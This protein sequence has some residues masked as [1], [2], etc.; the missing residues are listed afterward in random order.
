MIDPFLTHLKQTVDQEARA[1]AMRNADQKHTGPFMT[2]Y[3]NGIYWAPTS[4]V[5]GRGN[6]RTPE[7]EKMLSK[8]HFCPHLPCSIGLNDPKSAI[9]VSHKHYKIKCNCITFTVID[10]RNIGCEHEL[11]CFLLVNPTLEDAR[12]FKANDDGLGKPNGVLS[13]EKCS[14]YYSHIESAGCSEVKKK[15]IPANIRYKILVPAPIILC[16]CSESYYVFS[17]VYDYKAHHKGTAI[18]PKCTRPADHKTPNSLD[19]T[20]MDFNE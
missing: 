5:S 10:D 16:I 18:G 7:F 12:L 9:N 4:R 3:H 14:P 20:D 13:Y 11:N 2:Q 17:D 6:L 1:M 15:K 19:N 8:S